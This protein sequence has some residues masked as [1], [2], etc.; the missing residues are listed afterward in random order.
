M[1]TSIHVTLVFYRRTVKRERDDVSVCALN[2]FYRQP[3][4]Q[5]LYLSQLM[6]AICDGQTDLCVRNKIITSIE[7][8]ESEIQLETD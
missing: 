8:L 3:I 2:L 5:S 1:V 6:A 7:A 4:L